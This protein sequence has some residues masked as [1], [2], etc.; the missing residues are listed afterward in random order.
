MRL[1]IR[2]WIAVAAM[3]I[4]A[5][6]TAPPGMARAK[7]GTG[8]SPAVK[9]VRLQQKMRTHRIT[10]ARTSGKETVVTLDNGQTIRMSTVTYHRAQQAFATRSRTMTP[11]DEV[12]GDCGTAYINIHNGDPALQYI[13]STG[14]HVYAA[15]TAYG[16]SAYINGAGDHY[17]E[18]HYTSGGDLAFDN[19]WSGGHTGYVPAADL[20]SADIDIGGS[21]AWLYTDTMC[22]AGP[23][24]AEAY[25]FS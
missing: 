21:W 16:W 22:S 8:R 12:D 11:K 25:I 20:Y 13:M 5:V 10:K 7:T 24:F 15:A 1:K 23:A 18:Y 2:S 6:G 4:V 14:F 9:E 3:A 19:D 17:Y